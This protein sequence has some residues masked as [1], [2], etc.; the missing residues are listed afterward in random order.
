MRVSSSFTEE[1]KKEFD[2]NE[3]GIS[4]IGE[5][6]KYLTVRDSDKGLICLLLKLAKLLV[7]KKE[8]YGK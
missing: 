4:T 1:Q 2:D 6:K 8:Q 5:Y 3:R 7:I